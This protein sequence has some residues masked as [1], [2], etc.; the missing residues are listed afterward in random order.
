MSS[1]SVATYAVIIASPI[2]A[3]SRYSRMALAILQIVADLS[4]PIAVVSRLHRIAAASHSHR[5]A[6]VSHSRRIAAA[7]AVVTAVRVTR[8]GCLAP[9]AGWGC[10]PI[11][12]HLS[13]AI[14]VVAVSVIPTG[15]PIQGAFCL[16]VPAYPRLAAWTPA[17]RR[18]LQRC[19]VTSNP[20][21]HL[22]P[23]CRV[24]RVVGLRRSSHSGSEI[25]HRDSFRGW[26]LVAVAC[27]AAVVVV[28]VFRTSFSRL[29]LEIAAP[30]PHRCGPWRPLC[31][32]V[33]P[34][35]VAVLAR[36]RS[37]VMTIQPPS[38]T[39]LRMAITMGPTNRPTGDT[40]CNLHPRTVA[41]TTAPVPART[42]A[43]NR[44]AHLRATSRSNGP[45]PI[46]RNT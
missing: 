41:N 28:A 7:R 22:V 20:G 30:A 32:R 8:A 12:D 38:L 46:K 2:A 40:S 26:P 42:H 15:C 9:G 29:A 23:A 13:V 19:G 34:V 24:R 31:S 36:H 4:R 1:V 11:A 10:K 16:R 3:A 39:V 25:V 35:S 27:V 44:E 18:F 14:P 43:T 37:R 5:I 17:A 45:V 33:F 6:V 21:W